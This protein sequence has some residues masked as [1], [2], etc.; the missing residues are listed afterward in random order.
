MT[1]MQTR[2]KKTL[3]TKSY[4][5]RKK[6]RQKQKFNRFRHSPKIHDRKCPRDPTSPAAPPPPAQGS[7]LLR[8]PAY[9]FWR[10]PLVRGALSAIFGGGG[11]G[12]EGH[13]IR[14]PAASR[15]G[16]RLLR[17]FVYFIG[18]IRRSV[19]VDFFRWWCVPGGNV[20]QILSFFHPAG[21][22]VNFDV[23]RCLGIPKTCII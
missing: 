23:R 15:R 1:Y 11:A 3:R 10:V 5:H 12:G 4:I 9:W 8:R 20:G 13:S 6:K 22:S 16:I 17:P 14:P 19:E 2:N 18:G 21:I 7:V